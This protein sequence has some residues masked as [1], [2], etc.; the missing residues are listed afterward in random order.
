SEVADRYGAAI[1]AFDRAE[2]YDDPALEA[3]RQSLRAEASPVNVAASDA[4]HLFG[5]VDR[6]KRRGL[7]AKIDEHIATHPGS[8]QRAMAAEAGDTPITL[9]VC[10]RGN[11]A[12]VVKE[13]ARQCPA[14]LSAGD[15]KRKPFTQGSGRLELAR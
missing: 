15:D 4:E 7:K 10:L 13:V 1:A 14:I 11:A 6:M 12:T 5:N 8:P 2:P 3:V 9:R